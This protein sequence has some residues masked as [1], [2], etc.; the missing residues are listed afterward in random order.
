[1]TFD[2]TRLDALMG[3]R[4]DARTP[5][6]WTRLEIPRSRAPPLA[7]LS[8]V[9]YAKTLAKV[10][11]ACRRLSSF[12]ILLCSASNTQASRPYVVA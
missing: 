12:S 1:M 8:Q 2:E 5:C 6:P 11:K 4:R 3:R 7:E 9:E 10:I